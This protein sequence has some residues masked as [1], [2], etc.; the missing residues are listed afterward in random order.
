MTEKQEEQA[1]FKLNHS[2]TFDDIKK[3]NKLLEGSG[4]SV[5]KLFYECSALDTDIK[6]ASRY[7]Y[8]SEFDE[9]KKKYAFKR[10][11]EKKR[12]NILIGKEEEEAETNG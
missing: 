11:L 9:A 2:I 3:I 5:R 4:W 8:V 7:A 12:D 10:T 1:D 6:L